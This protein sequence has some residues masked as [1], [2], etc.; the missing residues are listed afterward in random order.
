MCC[1]KCF[2]HHKASS[3][4]FE[5]F[6][7]FRESLITSRCGARPRWREL[8][9]ARV[10]AEPPPDLGTNGIFVTQLIN[11]FECET[12]ELL[13]TL[14]SWRHIVDDISIWWKKWYIYIYMCIELLLESYKII[15]NRSNCKSHSVRTT[16]LA[17]YRVTH[18][19]YKR[20]IDIVK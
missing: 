3:H 20:I 7:S 15:R 8:S 9:V 4:H 14:S 16:L 17:T 6:S 19:S 1:M 12:V 5:V 13:R 11:S 2:V 18:R 10:S